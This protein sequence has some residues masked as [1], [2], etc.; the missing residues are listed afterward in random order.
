MTNT[1]KPNRMTGRGRFYAVLAG[2]AGLAAIL[3]YFEHLAVIYIIAAV[4]IFV[5]LLFAAYSN[6]EEASI[7]ATEEAYL[8]RQSEG[9][10]E[11]L[12]PK[13]KVN[14]WRER[15]APRAYRPNTAAAAES[16]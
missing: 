9:V 15:K 8:T 13:I 11:E 14:R 5:S 7:H 10:F 4:A 12:G 3:F 1:R 16:E 2:I 6:L